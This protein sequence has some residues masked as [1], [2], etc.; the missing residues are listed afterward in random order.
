MSNTQN[1]GLS[2]ARELGI[3]IETPEFSHVGLD[4]LQAAREGSITGTHAAEEAPINMRL[5]HLV[6]LGNT[7]T[8]IGIFK[9]DPEASR[10][11]DISD[12]FATVAAFRVREAKRIQEAREPEQPIFEDGG[13]VGL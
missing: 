6:A 7:D 4:G 2:L 12:L 9:D 11:T 5:G 3:L 8:D 10:E 1:F 13:A